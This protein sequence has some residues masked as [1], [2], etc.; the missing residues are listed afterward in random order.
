M[1]SV[2]AFLQNSLTERVRRDD[3][4]VTSVEYAL[5]LVLIVAALITAVT[6]F[7]G[8]L[9]AVFNGFKF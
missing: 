3:R 8:T 7:S 1:L 5:L 2:L 4:G 6:F 9:D